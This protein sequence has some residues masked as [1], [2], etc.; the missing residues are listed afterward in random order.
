MTGART[1]R[2]SF[3]Y[4]CVTALLVGISVQVC[5]GEMRK[6]WELR[7]SDLTESK[8]SDPTAFVSA[9]SFSP[10]GRYLAA[11]VWGDQARGRKT[12]FLVMVDLTNPRTAVRS[13]KVEGPAAAEDGDSPPTMSWSP[14]GGAV[15]V[16]AIVQTG[17]GTGCILA[18]TLRAVFYDIDR[19]ASGQASYPKSTIQFFD[20]ICG[21]MGTWEIDGKWR[22]SDASA[23]RHLLTL[24][25]DIPR[26]T[27]IL[28]ADPGEKSV[29]RRWALQNVDGAWPL[30][31]DRGR[32]V[33][34]LDGTGKNGVAHCW[35][36]DS[37]EQIAR[38]KTGNLHWPMKT[39]LNA[40]RAV[41]SDY[42]WR[43]YAEGL[44]SEIGSLKQRVVWDF[45][46]GKEITSWK[47][48][49]QFSTSSGSEVKEFN[50]FA[51]SPSG[52]SIAEGG[53]GALTLYRVVGAK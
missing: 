49:S 25:D 35:D 42:G 29:I 22:L 5:A 53:N 50:K 37:G 7:F 2:R 4:S 47:P 31:A 11:T 40:R 52:D 36:V 21:P 17:R 12:P 10:D 6:V 44:E 33:C 23:E 28:V 48:R 9:V 18:H 27:Q 34:A 43:I 19:V 38:T 26:Q 45:G 39:A 14:D 20:S 24:S 32:A 16:P 51:I 3:R 46:T 13:F 15:A 30:F 8:I 1:V 41:L